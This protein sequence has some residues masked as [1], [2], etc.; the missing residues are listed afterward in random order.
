[1]YIG[2]SLEQLGKLPP[3]LR[4]I[5]VTV[6]TNVEQIVL[7]LRAPTVEAVRKTARYG[8]FVAL[9][10]RAVS[11]GGLDRAASMNTSSCWP[12]NSRLPPVSTA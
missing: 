11:G 12:T 6:A 2:P 3:L 1:M 7:H 9:V 4:W 10:L 5:G 8:V